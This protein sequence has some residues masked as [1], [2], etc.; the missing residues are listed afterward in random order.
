[1][2]HQAVL[3]QETIQGLQIE[4][5]G[6][7]VDVTFGSG[8]HSREILS[9]LANGR[10]FGFDQ[11]PDAALNTISDE[12]FTFIQGNFRH[13]KNFLRLY[14]VSSI[15]GLLADLGISSWQIDEPS[16]GFS[17]RS[18]GHLDMRM[19]KKQALDAFHVVNH[20]EEDALARIFKEYGEL[21]H[22]RQLA[23][24]IIEKRAASAISTTAQFKEALLPVSPRGKENQFLSKAFQAVR[25]EVN[26]EL[27][28]L[29]ELL[30]QSRDLLTE[31]GRIAVIS[32]H[33][34]EDRLVKNFFRAGNFEGIIEK[35]FYGHEITPL[36]PVFRK[37][38]VPRDAELLANPRARS[39]KLRIAEKKTD[40]H[41]K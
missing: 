14:Q 9:R 40:R 1:M 6:I 33:S 39:A 30:I 26:D 10:L 24:Q 3:L 13:L 22:P 23:R 21:E 25:I 41:G 36:R 34:L 20:Y 5:S 18:D 8:G 4:P 2:Y 15:H 37:A 11:D 32:Y 28:S 38:M 19:D 29:K 7:Y 17:T 16:R 12:R 31:S 27:E 35:D